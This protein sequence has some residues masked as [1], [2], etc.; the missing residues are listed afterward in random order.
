M[1]HD[2]IFSIMIHEKYELIIALTELARQLTELR[3]EFCT[4]EEEYE[5][6][7]K[8]EVKQR[9]ASQ[10]QLLENLRQA[11]SQP[12]QPITSSIASSSQP[13]MCT[14]KLANPFARVSY[15]IDVDVNIKPFFFQVFTLVICNNKTD[16]PN[17]DISLYK[18]SKA[19]KQNPIKMRQKVTSN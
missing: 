6:S 7:K 18:T 3:P 5:D 2:A 10:P 14:D 11:A 13:A 1:Y 4:I 17:R 12:I 16:I 8:E 19:A 15:L 9:W